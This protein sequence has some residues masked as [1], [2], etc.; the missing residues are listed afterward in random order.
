MSAPSNPKLRVIEIA[1]PV[2]VELP[3]GFESLL[4]AVVDLVCKKYEAAN[5]LRVMWPAGYGH[6]PLWREPEEPDFDPSVYFIDVA[7]REASERELARRAK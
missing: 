7:E 6:K 3:D 4:Y 5:P 2:E 1:F